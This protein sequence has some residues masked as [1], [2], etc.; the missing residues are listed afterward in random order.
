MRGI[1]GRVAVVTGAGRGI[2]AAVAKRLAEEG[3]SVAVLDLTLE[4]TEESVAEIV[5]AGGEARGYAC[6]VAD[7]DS[8]AAAFVAIADGFGRGAGIL[9]NNAGITQDAM[10]HKMTVAQWDRVMAVHLR[11][12]FLCT[13]AAQLQMVPDRWGRIINLSSTAALG[14]RGQSNYSAAKAGLQGFTKTVSLEL[15]R[16]GITVNAIAPGF[17]ISEMTRAAAASMKLDWPEFEAQQV[18]RISVGR[19]GT[20]EDVAGLAAFL[21]SDDASFITGQVVYLT[22]QPRT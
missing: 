6:D 22:G 10:L 2:G 18:S 17:I 4:N 21:A 3:A 15:G 14:N 8:V 13:R 7:E 11:G 5:A 9:V 19:G 12:S 16:F 1:S 20:P